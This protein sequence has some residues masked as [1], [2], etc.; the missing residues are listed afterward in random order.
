[1]HSLIF[2]LKEAMGIKPTHFTQERAEAQMRF[3]HLNSHSNYNE[4][5][6]LIPAVLL[7]IVTSCD[8]SQWGMYKGQNS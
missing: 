6:N 4:Q 1:M 2:D 3:L 5:Q 7:N 8:L